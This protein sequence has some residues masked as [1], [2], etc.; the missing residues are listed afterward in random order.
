MILLSYDVN[1]HVYSKVKIYLT[2]YGFSQ[3]RS[4][5]ILTLSCTDLYGYLLGL[6]TN[7]EVEQML[8]W[9]KYIYWSLT[10]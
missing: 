10:L 5:R 6:L 8:I 9:S 4:T 3:Y 2:S 7:Y 1:D